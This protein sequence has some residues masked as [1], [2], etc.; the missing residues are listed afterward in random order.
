MLW[1]LPRNSSQ[2]VWGLIALCCSLWVSA[3]P[4]Q[5]TSSP[6][7]QASSNMSQWQ[8]AFRMMAEAIS[9]NLKYAYVLDATHNNSRLARR[10]PAGS[11][12]GSLESTGSSPEQIPENLAENVPQNVPEELAAA[13]AAA[14][15]HIPPERA[16]HIGLTDWDAI[17]TTTYNPSLEI[18][19]DGPARVFP[20][21]HPF[22]GV[23][24]QTAHSMCA[25]RAVGGSSWVFKGP[26]SRH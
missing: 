22:E 8:D 25:A 20:A 10:S 17:F 3:A 6:S 15:P 5:A 4:N 23:N 12:A 9:G 16:N 2:L 1:L 19:C 13:G 14:E 21:G 18:I 24:F 11:D 7:P 26:K